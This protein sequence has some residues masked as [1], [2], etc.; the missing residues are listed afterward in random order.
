M[1]IGQKRYP[2][3]E[4]DGTD[5]HGD[6]LQSMKVN[7]FRERLLTA[8][9]TN[10]VRY[11]SQLSESEVTTKL[12]DIRGTF[13]QETTGKADLQIDVE[14]II[15]GY[16]FKILSRKDLSFDTINQLYKKILNLGFIDLTEESTIG[17]YFGQYC[18]RLGHIDTAKEVLSALLV[19]ANDIAAGPPG[20]RKAL[21]KHAKLALAKIPA[22]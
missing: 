6:N 5:V 2:P 3:A 9:A 13:L 16:K 15:T 4:G 12:D 14:R 8:I 7:K 1:G 11:E 19:R 17:I 18:T 10:V 20:V 21:E 22:K